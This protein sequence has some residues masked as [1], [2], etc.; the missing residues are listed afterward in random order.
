MKTNCFQKIL[1]VLCAAA[2][3]LCAAAAF[4]QDVEPGQ[5]IPPESLAGQTLTATLK[6]YDA[7][8]QCFPAVFYEKDTFDK[9]TVASLK[10]GDKLV[11]WDNEYT[12]ESIGKSPMETMELTLDSGDEILLSEQEDGTFLAMAALDDMICM[13]VKG[14]CSLKP[15]AD[16]I[17]TDASDIE[18]EEPTVLTGLDAIL[19][20]QAQRE[21][22]SIGF[23]YT[24]TTITL[25]ENAEII[26][27]RIDYAPWQ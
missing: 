11:L 9:E 14:E 10:A 3:L 4:A 18:A 26:E 6:T 24:V 15:A 25:N 19:A 7:E 20:L 2:M 17:L 12:I 16:I 21:E 13:H 22:E 5:Q 1:A 8:N 27:I 23:D